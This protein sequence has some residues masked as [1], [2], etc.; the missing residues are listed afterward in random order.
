MFETLCWAYVLQACPCKPSLYVWLIRPLLAYASPGPNIPAHVLILRPLPR[1][2]PG[3][4]LRWGACSNNHDHRKRGS[5][6]SHSGSDNCLEYVPRRRDGA[7]KYPYIHIPWQ[8]KKLP[9]ATKKPFH[10]RLRPKHI[11]RP[12]SYTARVREHNR[13]SSLRTPRT[14]GS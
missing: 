5:F 3:V 9:A 11:H 14:R 7:L 13:S 2:A 8:E 10:V 6:R 12:R 1:D 4:K